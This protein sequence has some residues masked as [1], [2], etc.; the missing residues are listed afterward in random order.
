MLQVKVVRGERPDVEIH[1]GIELDQVG[2]DF[3]YLEQEVLG[4]VQEVVNQFAWTLCTILNGTDLDGPV[5]M[6]LAGLKGAIVQ[7]EL[8]FDAGGPHKSSP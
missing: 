6:Y 2:T 5:D 1:G 3:E 4:H 7:Y 8:L